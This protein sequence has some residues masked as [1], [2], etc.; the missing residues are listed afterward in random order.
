MT[1]KRLEKALITALT[2]GAGN[3]VGGCILPRCVL[4]GSS[5][6]TKVHI[7]RDA[8]IHFSV[9]FLLSF[10]VSLIMPDDWEKAK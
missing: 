2:F 3:A 9:A 1:K 10:V 8:A 5:E 7:W 6:E 4:P